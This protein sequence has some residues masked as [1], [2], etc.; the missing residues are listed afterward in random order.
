MDPKNTP[1]TAPGC[2]RRAELLQ[3][4]NKSGV[5]RAFGRSNESYAVLYHTRSNLSCANN[6]VMQSQYCLFWKR[7]AFSEHITSSC[8]FIEDFRSRVDEAT[9]PVVDN[10]VSSAYESFVVGNCAL[11]K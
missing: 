2:S 1:R 11:A 7:F 5:T 8:L 4:L 6:V 3:Q 9:R 10:R